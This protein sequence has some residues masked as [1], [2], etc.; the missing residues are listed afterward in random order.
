MPSDLAGKALGS[1]RIGGMQSFP[2]LR[3][4]GRGGD[5][6]RPLAPLPLPDVLDLAWVPADLHPVSDSLTT[7]CEESGPPGRLPPEDELL[8]AH[9]R[10]AARDPETREVYIEERVYFPAWYSYGGSHFSAI[11]AGGT[12][13]VLAARRP[14]GG[15]L[16]GERFLAPPSALLLIGVALFVPTL[17]GKLAGV[18]FTAVLL[19]LL[20]RWL[21]ARHG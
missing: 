10:Q 11:V 5:Q 17:G 4:K 15:R 9:L 13:R 16:M 14:P 12:A 18:A 19:F 8:R 1:L 20:L 6:W 21:V 3:V 7:F 2:F